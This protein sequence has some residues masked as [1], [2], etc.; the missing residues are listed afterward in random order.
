MIGNP[1]DWSSTVIFLNN[2][3]INI[4]VKKPTYLYRY[5]L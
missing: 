2:K 5:M 3:T 1:D 4:N